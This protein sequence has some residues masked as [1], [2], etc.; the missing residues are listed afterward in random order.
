MRLL[1]ASEKESLSSR[2][3]VQS[4][5]PRVEVVHL[6]S[7]G[8]AVRK[9]CSKTIGSHLKAGFPSL[10]RCIIPGDGTGLGGG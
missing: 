9:N 2:I 5:P 4:T 8:D 6:P 10:V 7:P 3:P 1:I